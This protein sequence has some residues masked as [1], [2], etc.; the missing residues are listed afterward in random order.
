M[1]EWIAAGAA[2]EWPLGLAP[3]RLG[4]NDAWSP[5][6]RQGDSAR[7]PLG[8]VARSPPS[9]SA[10]PAGVIPST[11]DTMVA[12]SASVQGEFVAG[13]AARWSSPDR[14]GGGACTAQSCPGF[15][16]N[17]IPAR[18]Q[19]REL[20]AGRSGPD[21]ILASVGR[22]PAAFA[23]PCAVPVLVARLP[24][25]GIVRVRTVAGAR[26]R[27]VLPRSCAGRCAYR[28]AACGCTAVSAQLSDGRVPVL[29]RSSVLCR[30][31][32][33]GTRQSDRAGRAKP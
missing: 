31:R 24:R 8:A 13:T 14:C 27:D 4:T 19:S 7:A 2:A 32:C 1:A 11:A 5:R 30:F 26:T 10:L 3:R 18:I 15:L 12:F 6:T 16:A 33:R 17:R 29:S 9:L 25:A 28:I 21:A 20:S 22:S 23:L